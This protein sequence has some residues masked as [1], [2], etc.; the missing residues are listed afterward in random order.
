M[1]RF[2]VTAILMLGLSA[3]A[4]EYEHD[5]AYEDSPFAAAMGDEAGV[6]GERGRLSAALEAEMSGG[7]G[8]ELGP[9]YRSDS[10]LELSSLIEDSVHFYACT[11]GVQTQTGYVAGQYLNQARNEC[12]ALG[13]SFASHPVE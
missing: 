5:L 11:F 12:H 3:C 10:E 6:D 4:L 1:K 2:G 13:G 7:D 9:R 8:Y